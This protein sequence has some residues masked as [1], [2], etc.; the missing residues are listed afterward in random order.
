MTTPAG[1]NL[2]PLAPLARTIA[3]TI[4]DTPVRLGS[5]EGAADLVATLTVKVAAYMGHELGTDARILG[6]IVAE[7]ER[8]DAK[9]GEQNHPDGTGNQSQQERADFARRWCDSAFQSGYGTW[10]DVL[11]EE[12][13]EASAESDPAKLRTELI[14]VA[15][16]AINWIGAID[17]RTQQPTT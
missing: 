13:A 3:E 11:A 17:R 6:E 14:Q 15:A 9:W 16:V 2:K 12:V 8:Q 1:T 4:R 5:P 10:A 7:R